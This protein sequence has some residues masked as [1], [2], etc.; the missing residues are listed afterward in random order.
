MKN[1]TYILIAVSQSSLARERKRQNL[2]STVCGHLNVFTYLMAATTFIQNVL[3]SY[4][5]RRLQIAHT[6]WDTRYRNQT[7]LHSPHH[8][9]ASI[10]SSIREEASGYTS[11]MAPLSNFP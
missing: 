5:S 9:A 6:M 10:G 8:I 4:L 1:L 3:M 2:T 11:K 7:D